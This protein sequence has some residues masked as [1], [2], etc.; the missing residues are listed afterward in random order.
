MLTS[1]FVLNT[2]KYIYLMIILQVV[3]DTTVDWDAILMFSVVVLLFVGLV[4]S[5]K[6]HL[7]IYIP[8]IPVPIKR[9]RKAILKQYFPYYNKLPEAQKKHFEHKVQHFIYIKDFIPRQ[10]GE[11]SEEMKVLIAACAVQLTFGY[12]K[13]FLSHFKRILIYPTNYYSTIN[14]QYHKGEV[15]PRLG[16]IVLSWDNFTKGYINPTDGRN[17]GL[18]EMAHALHFEDRINNTEYAFL[19]QKALKNWNSLANEEI[20]KIRNGQDHMFRDYAATNLSEFFSVAIENFF[21]RPTEFK[22]ELP[23]LFHNL[24]LILKQ[25]PT[26]F[27]G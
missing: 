25:D 5:K 8:N 3:N 1:S 13:V 26:I 12:P 16:A 17:L 6:V 19:D 7:G 9:A 11:V 21:E 22:N 4:L 20:K 27:Y 18:H 2:L 14:Q 23:E 10:I 15:N 24:T